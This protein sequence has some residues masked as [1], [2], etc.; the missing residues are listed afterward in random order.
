[1]ARHQVMCCAY[2]K[3][4]LDE[5]RKEGK[6]TQQQYRSCVEVNTRLS[7]NLH[8]ATQ[9]IKYLQ[10]LLSVKQRQAQQESQEVASPQPHPEPQGQQVAPVLV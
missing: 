6:S 2:L 7:Q 4:I 9:T 10:F 1:M 8:H 5:A 3:R